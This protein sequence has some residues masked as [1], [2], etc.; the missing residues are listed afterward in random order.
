MMGQGEY[1]CGLEPATHA[2]ASR[3]ELAEKDFPHPLAPGERVLYELNLTI[4]EHI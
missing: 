2:M 3:A 4:V 1:V